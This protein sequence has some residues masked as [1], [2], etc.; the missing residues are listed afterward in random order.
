MKNKKMESVE[1]IHEKIVMMSDMQDTL[2]NLASADWNS[3]NYNWDL[4]I[5]VENSELID[6]L[7]YKHWKKTIPDYGQ[8]KLEVLDIL[9]FYLSKI[10][11][12]PDS[13]GNL[14]RLSREIFRFQETYGSN[15]IVKEESH[16]KALSTLMT[17][18]GVAANGSFSETHM[19]TLISMFVSFEELCNLYVGK[20]AL[21]IFRQKNGYKEGSYIKVWDG[22][23]DNEVLTEIVTGQGITN[24]KEIYLRLTDEYSKI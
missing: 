4:Y 22:K 13:N 24:F 15:N 21:N 6:H 17:I 8:C 10:L 19:C 9:H 2:N 3:K 11:N 23:E 12:S 1:N 5:L 20:N 7:G 14:I 18:S 16:K